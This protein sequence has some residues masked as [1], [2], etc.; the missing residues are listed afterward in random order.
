M[1]HSTALVCKPNLGLRSHSTS[2]LF[3]YKPLRRCP[4]G[5]P[6]TQHNC[7]GVT[8]FRLPGG[9]GC[10][11]GLHGTSSIH[12]PKL[13]SIHS[14]QGHQ[15]ENDKI[16]ILELKLAPKLQTKDKDLYCSCSA[17]K[18]EAGFFVELITVTFNKLGSSVGSD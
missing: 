1:L 18:L 8:K 9:R 2:F 3:F 15:D 11:F 7:R 16:H 5:S 6:S 4:S 10:Y 17:K 13:I 12:R 14:G